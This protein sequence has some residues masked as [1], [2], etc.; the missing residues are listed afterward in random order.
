[1]LRLGRTLSNIEPLPAETKAFIRRA[2]RFVPLPCL[3]GRQSKGTKI[4]VIL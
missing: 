3:L 1:M 2:I 4:Q